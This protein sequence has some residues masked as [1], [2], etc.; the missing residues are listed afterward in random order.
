MMFLYYNHDILKAKTPK[1]K[2]VFF[3][4]LCI[5]FHDPVFFIVNGRPD[6]TFIFPRNVCD[7]LLSQQLNNDKNQANP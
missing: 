5:F 7:L 3:V 1:H 2:I 4:L 6:R